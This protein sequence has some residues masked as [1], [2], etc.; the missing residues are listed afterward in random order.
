MLFHCIITLPIKRLDY[1]L[2]S[3]LIRD[4]PQNSPQIS[5]I[6]SITE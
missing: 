3:V 4:S 6:Q 2:D 5:V 1:N